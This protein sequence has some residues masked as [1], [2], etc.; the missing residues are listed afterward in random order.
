MKVRLIIWCGLYM[1]KDLKADD[2]PE[3]RL[4]IRE[5]VCGEGPGILVDN[6]LSMSQECALVAK[7]SDVLKC[8]RKNIASRVRQVILTL[9]S[10]QMCNSS[11]FNPTSQQH[12]LVWR[13]T[14]PAQLFSILVAVKYQLPDHEKTQEILDMMELKK[15]YIEQE[16][17]GSMHGVHST[18]IRILEVTKTQAGTAQLQ[19][20]T[21]TPA[22]CPMK[23]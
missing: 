22:N 5:W 6:K 9:C 3:M 21:H 17:A 15:T 7:D 8:I 20:L 16:Q 2:T 1:D 14:T 10:A 23:H 11:C 4:I 19:G 12:G 13:L 18:Q